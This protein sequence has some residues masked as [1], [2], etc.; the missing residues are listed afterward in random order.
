ML[1]S[2][3]LLAPLACRALEETTPQAKFTNGHN[4][5]CYRKTVVP[6]NVH[7]FGQ[8]AADGLTCDSF[9]HDEMAGECVLLENDQGP[10]CLQQVIETWIKTQ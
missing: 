10:G 5:G 2:L 7:D 3:L 1:I 8:C 9:I 6:A 4:S